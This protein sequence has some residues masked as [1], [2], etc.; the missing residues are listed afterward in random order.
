MLKTILVPIDISHDAAGSRSVAMARKVMDEGGRLVLLNVL[1]NAPAYV[2]SQIPESVLARV[3]NEAEADLKRIAKENALPD[4]TQTLI[5]RGR[6]SNTI[7]DV[8]KDVGADAI[9][10]ASH[11]PTFADHLLGSVA[12][13]V[14]RHAQCSV[15]VVRGVKS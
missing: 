7:L 15:F 10:V 8:A 3:A 6:P 9:V 2:A 5:K 12:S 14:V 4:D 1:E 13:R 11:N